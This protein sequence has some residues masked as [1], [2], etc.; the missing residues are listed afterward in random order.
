MLKRFLTMVGV[1]SVVAVSAPEARAE[2]DVIK[3]KIGT[4]A[5]KNSPWG[6][7]FEV[8]Q[9][10]VSKRTNGKMEL[11]FFWNGTQG[12]ESGMAGKIRNGQ[13]DG[14][15]LTATGL[16]QFSKSI[17][18]LE[19]PG[20]SNGDWAKVDKA[21]ADLKAIMD[22]EFAAQ[23][24]IL[25]GSG[26]VGLTRILSIGKGVK[27]PND[28]KEL[29]PFYISGDPLGKTMLTK[30]GVPL[31]SASVPEILPKLGTGIKILVVPALAAEQLQWASKITHAT[32]MVPSVSV[33]GLVLSS[34]KVGGLN[35]DLKTALLETAEV[36]GK[37]LTGRIRRED[38]AAWD[39]LKKKVEVVEPSAADLA[40]WQKLFGQ[41]R[42]ELCGS[43][44]K[45]EACDLA[46]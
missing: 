20:W 10:G 15:A 23:K 4:L 28:V 46:K 37:A 9:K 2:D 42:S 22:P 27:S 35:A 44:I 6:Q 12:D 31:Q 25:A 41:V 1:F 13:L 33:G 38:A 26:D 7:V 18:A 11:E 21:R 19:L 43:T 5:P 14:A 17:L 40:E 36:A 8:W 3:I 24:V 39:R 16:S 30:L 32:T 29:S 45:K 34:D